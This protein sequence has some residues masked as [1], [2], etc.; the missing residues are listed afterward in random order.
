MQTEVRDR[1]AIVSRAIA[2]ASSEERD[3]YIA[4]A[5]GNDAALRRQVEEQVRA[6][7]LNGN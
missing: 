6:H 4:E 1:D 5:C 2:I 7:F 3:A